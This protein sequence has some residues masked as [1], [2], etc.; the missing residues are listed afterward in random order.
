MQP[1]RMMGALQPT[2]YEFSGLSTGCGRAYRILEERT[3]VMQPSEYPEF[4]AGRI[5]DVVAQ[6]W[7]G[8]K[9]GGLS[10]ALSHAV[11]AHNRR[12]VY[13]DGTARMYGD[14]NDPEFSH[15]GVP[16]ILWT[17]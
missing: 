15:I 3:D 10:W 2:T 13:A 17:P 16:P 5:S 11:V 6:A 1:A 12:A 14:T 4:L 7:K 9:P 8:R